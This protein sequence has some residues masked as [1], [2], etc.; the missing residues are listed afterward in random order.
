MVKL[1]MAVGRDEKKTRKTNEE[2]DFSL[3]VPPTRILYQHKW[4]I[5]GCYTI[6]SYT[7]GFRMS[8][9][10]RTGPSTISFVVRVANPWTNCTPS[11]RDIISWAQYI[12][13]YLQISSR[14][15]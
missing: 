10:K 15:T 8:F 4:L 14:L 11:Y 5:R 1:A 6:Y 9:S 12:G 7:Y 13:V 2:R 3:L